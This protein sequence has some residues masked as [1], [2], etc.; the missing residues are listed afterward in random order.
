MALLLTYIDLLE[1]LFVCIHTRR[2]GA[3][4]C[5]L[6]NKKCGLLTS[7]GQWWLCSAGH[8]C[9]CCCW[10]NS[11]PGQLPAPGPKWPAGLPQHRL[12][13]ETCFEMLWCALPCPPAPLACPT[14]RPALHCRPPPSLLAFLY[15]A[16]KPGKLA[17]I[18]LSYRRSLITSLDFVVLEK[19]T[20]VQEEQ[21][22]KHTWYALC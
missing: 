2:I 16:G 15:P 22:A 9:R 18:H 4:S 6:V 3:G 5:G 13:A 10:S 11:L 1:K 7:I 19:G 12:A 21:I 14:R 20:L 8:C 17:I